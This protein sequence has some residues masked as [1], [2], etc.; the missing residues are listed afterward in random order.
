MLDTVSHE[1]KLVEYNTIA[2]SFG[3]LSQKVKELQDYICDKYAPE[4]NFN[5]K[6]PMRELPEDLAYLYK[7]PYIDRLVNCF[8]TATDLYRDSVQ[9][10]PESRP[11]TVLFMVEDNE[12]NVIDQKVIE[13]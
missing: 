2:C 13:L 4:M 11:L 6:M 1:M 9:I 8:K 12:R 10:G 5:Y 3:C 7:E